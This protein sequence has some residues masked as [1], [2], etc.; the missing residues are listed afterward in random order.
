M[1]SYLL[2]ENLGRRAADALR[3]AGLSAR[4]VREAGLRGQPDTAVLDY[5]RQTGLVL[6]TLDLDFSNVHRFP[7]GCHAG[8]VVGRFRD[9]TPAELVAARFVAVLQRLTD[10][11]L[12]GNLVVV[13]PVV[14]RIRRHRV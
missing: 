6:V 5:A 2:D 13:S 3:S 12:H 10:D 14:L 4:T 9:D 7:L 11:D 8:I 1:A